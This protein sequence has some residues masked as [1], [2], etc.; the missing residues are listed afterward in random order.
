MAAKVAQEIRLG[1]LFVKEGLITQQQLQE[2]LT[3]YILD[4]QTFDLDG[5]RS[6]GE[7]PAHVATSPRLVRRCPSGCSASNPSDADV[8]VPHTCHSPRTS[9][10]NTGRLQHA[11]RST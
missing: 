8:A 7:N 3:D 1:D 4:G 2:G 6:I 10:V 9:A 5:V 11:L